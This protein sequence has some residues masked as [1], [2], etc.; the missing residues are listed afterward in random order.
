[1]F[2]CSLLLTLTNDPSMQ[3]KTDSNKHLDITNNFHNRRTK[4]IYCVFTDFFSPFENFL[5]VVILEFLQGLKNS[6][7][8]FSVHCSG[9]IILAYLI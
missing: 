1:M 7:L 6:N 5:N 2:V 4:V 9:K 3:K 8:S